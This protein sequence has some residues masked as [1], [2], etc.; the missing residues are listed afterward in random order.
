MTEARLPVRPMPKC[1]K[2]MHIPR[3]LYDTSS[4]EHCRCRDGGGMEYAKHP[5]AEYRSLVVGGV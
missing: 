5:S 1:R 3:Q 2:N 4:N